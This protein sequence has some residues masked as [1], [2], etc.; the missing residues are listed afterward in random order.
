MSL[1]EDAIR[2]YR[3]KEKAKEVEQA[4]SKRVS[5]ARRIVVARENICKTFALDECPPLAVAQN[6]AEYWPKVTFKVDG[7]KFDYCIDNDW[8][9]VEVSC[10]KCEGEW[11][12]QFRVPVD[13]NGVRDLSDLGYELCALE[14]HDCPA[15][16]PSYVPPPPPQT[17]T[18]R[19]DSVE[20]RLLDSLR[21][22]V[23]DI[24]E[25]EREGR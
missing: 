13:R 3:E 25:Q 15:D 14:R 4:E 18:Y 10:P 24:V 7:I 1:R 20:V 17:V 22:Y 12:R 11:M 21:E 23:F 8:L 6:M 2:A 16:K 9:R 5:V 19:A